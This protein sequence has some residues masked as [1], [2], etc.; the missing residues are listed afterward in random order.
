MVSNILSLAGLIAGVFLAFCALLYWR[1]DSFIFFPRPN[2]ALLVQKNQ[3]NRVEIRGPG[4]MLEGWWATNPKAT[5][6]LVI[7]Y[8]GGNAE[9][10]LDTATTASLFDA[11]RMLVVNYRGYGRSAGHPG[12]RALY[13]DGLAI[14]Q[15]AITAVGAKPE[16]I[17]VMGRSLGSGVAAMLAAE[18]KVRGAVL[19]T[20]FDS[21]ASVAA[22][23]Y[24]FI[25]VRL[26][27]RHRFPSTHWAKRTQAPVLIVAAQGDGIIP[28]VHAERLFEAWAGPK[29]IHVLEGV[30]H[31]DIELHADYYT[32]IDDFLRGL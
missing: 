26:L 11:Q 7:I 15:Y 1:Q 14:Y 31:N 10:V 3:A 29:Q 16:D 9:D 6:R 22:R 5:T 8:F 25:P 30:S 28:P 17:V 24:W 27:L 13:E 2:D 32:L 21:L 4:G 20:P 19:I 23:H 18:R 12:Q